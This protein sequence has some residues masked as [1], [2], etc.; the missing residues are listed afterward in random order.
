MGAGTSGNC[1][2]TQHHTNDVTSVAF[3][4]SE[5][6]VTVIHSVLGARSD[7]GW[8][9]MTVGEREGALRNARETFLSED[10]RTDPTLRPEIVS[11]W[12]RSRMLGVA[13]SGAD[14][15]YEPVLGGANRLLTAAANPVLDWLADHLS[16]GTAVI[17]ADADA[18]ILDRRTDGRTVARHL[19]KVLAVPGSCFGEEHIGTNGIG[20]V[21][22]S[23]GPV[24]IAG[25]EHYRDNLQDFT[26]VGAPLRHP[27]NRRVVGVLD[28]CCRYDDTSALMKPLMLAAS[29]E[30]ESRMYAESSLR[31]RMLLEEFLQVSRRSSAAVVSLN[32]DFII[33]NTSAAKLL[34]PEDH[35]LLWDWASTV[36]TGRGDCAGE[37]RLGR[38]VVVHARGRTVGEDGASAA[39][40]LI[41]MRRQSAGSPHRRPARPTSA[42]HDLLPGRS[43]VWQRACQD[44]AVAGRSG[45]DVLVTGEPGTGKM[46]AARHVGDPDATTVMDAALADPGWLDRVGRR[47][48][49][50]GT[51]VLR[52]LDLT[53]DAA[54]AALAALLDARQGLPARIVAT[55]VQ[56]VGDTPAVRL[57]DRFPARVA[58][59]PLRNRPEDLADIAP[60]LIR[61]RTGPG[62]LPR[63]QAATLQALMA[64]GWP[65][66]VRELDAVLSAA[67]LRAMGS[68]VALTHLPPEYRQTAPRRAMPSL[69]RAERETILEALTDA[70]GNKLVAAERLGIARSTL[71]RKMRALGIDEKRWGA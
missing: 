7:A 20:S 47:L 67:L 23:A 66:N 15:P 12:R 51:L 54:C 4:D 60:V 11:S 31:E 62:P 30:I 69:K 32:Q 63:L 1:P 5:T 43:A 27:V 48:G 9:L 57:L 36:M 14:V 18:R 37:V 42:S 13:P 40:V 44:L 10:G 59:P 19:D 34:D 33:T 50:P 64:L 22:E 2:T 38:D 52:H 49:L 6:P 3:W 53:P 21:L 65:G 29:R 41:E 61:G 16:G 45:L 26:C 71:Y 35:A 24:M 28:V 70:A 25:A 46:H 8:C 56:P 58:L 68:D 55:A 17:L 39:G